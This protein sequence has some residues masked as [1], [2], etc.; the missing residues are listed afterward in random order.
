VVVQHTRICTEEI[1]NE[2]AMVQHF[3]RT[4]N[5]DSNADAQEEQVGYRVRRS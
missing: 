3:A 1:V 5:L 4:T 2:L